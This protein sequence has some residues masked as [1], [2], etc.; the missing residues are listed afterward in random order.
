[1]S[2]QHKNKLVTIF[3]GTSII[4]FATFIIFIAIKNRTFERQ[5]TYYTVIDDAHG[6]QNNPS[7]FYKGV[8][9]GRVK[10]FKLTEDKNIRVDFS[11]YQ[12][13]MPLIIEY[14]VVM[15]NSNPISGEVSEFTLITPEIKDG[16]INSVP[17]PGSL[18]PEIS[19]NE[20][21]QYIEKGR[22]EIPAK[23]IDAVAKKVNML[24]DSLVANKTMNKIDGSLTHINNAIINL[25]ELLGS[26]KN[27]DG[28]AVKLGGKQIETAVASLGNSI[29]YLEDMLKEIHNNKRMLTPIMLNTNNTIQKLDKTLQGVNNN[30]IIKNGIQK[31]QTTDS[32]KIGVEIND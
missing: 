2:Y 27:P 12:E 20:G 5:Y 17:M 23:G 28:L 19:S 16:I 7:L 24:L 13:Y 18:L 25:E 10:K 30:P 8:E 4:L 15:K 32:S 29:K 31:K 11:I 9:I 3:V 6:L 1:M 14:S 26:Y 22:I 21:I